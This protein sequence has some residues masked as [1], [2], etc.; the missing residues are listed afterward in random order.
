[1]AL[2]FSTALTIALL[3]AWLNGGTTQAV[4][5]GAHL[6]IRS[7]A[8]PATADTLPAGTVGATMDLPAD[9]MAGTAGHTC[10]KQGTWSDTSA[11]ASITAAHFEVYYTGDLGTTNTVDKRLRGTVSATGGGG[12][13]TLD[14]ISVA[15]GQPVVVGSFQFTLPA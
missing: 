15:I 6:R 14:N 13:M 7:G 8:A 5:D 2:Q 11:D 3:D 10:A 12:D 1:M 4:F 9:A